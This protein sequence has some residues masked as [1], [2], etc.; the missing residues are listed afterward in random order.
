MVA[1]IQKNRK[2]LKFIHS[3]LNIKRTKC[4]SLV[5][6]AFALNFCFYLCKFAKT[7]SKTNPTH[8]RLI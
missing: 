8:N 6:Y 7:T 2:I 4:I 5:A 3:A 1:F